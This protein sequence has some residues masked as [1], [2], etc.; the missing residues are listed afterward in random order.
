[1]CPSMPEVQEYHRKLAERLVMKYKADGFKVDGMY[2]CPPCYNPAH[3]HKNPNESS[4]DFHKVFKSFYDAAKSIDSTITI[5]SCPCG[6]VC[7]YTSLPY[8]TET[9]AADP[10]SLKTVRRKAKL[11]RALKGNHTPYSSD[12]ID[13]TKGNLHF[14]VSFANAVGIGAVPQAFYGTH[15]SADTAEIY[16]KWFSIYFNEMISKAEYLNLYD[17]GFDYPETH[18][19][20][21]ELNGKET[22]YYSFFADESEW[23]GNIE[24]RGLD[25]NKNYVVYDYVN[26]KELGVLKGES[27]VMSLSFKNFLLVRCSSK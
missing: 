27:P 15:P 25:E 4:E 3:N 21:K 8:I 16:D 10:K 5:M 17:M 24:F 18:V 11:Y 7:D 19:L 14:P 2:V 13:I 26:N 22:Y 6:A 12:Y 9:I 23:S 1:M 20:R